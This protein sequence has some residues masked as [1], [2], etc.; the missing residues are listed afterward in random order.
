MDDLQQPIGKKGKLFPFQG[1]IFPQVRL[2]LS[3]WASRTDDAGP[4]GCL[5]Y[6]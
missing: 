6:W 2:G 3:P 1:K 4:L 5:W